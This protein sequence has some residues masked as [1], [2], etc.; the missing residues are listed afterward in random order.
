MP[1]IPDLQLLDVTIGYPGVPFGEYPQEWYGLGSVFWRNVPPPTVRIHLH[2]Y[3]A[4]EVPSLP[5][6]PYDAA[7]TPLATPEEAREFELW[8]RQVWT[9]KERR[10]EQMVNDED[11]EKSPPSEVVTIT[12]L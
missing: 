11:D 5:R 8:L 7:P 6:P 4:N 10:L 2:L 12:Q 1:S 9:Q 3:S